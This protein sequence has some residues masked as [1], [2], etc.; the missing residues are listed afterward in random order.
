MCKQDNV[1]SNR[2]LTRRTISY[3]VRVNIT[4]LL[5]SRGQFHKNLWI[6]KLRICS[7]YQILTVNL[8]INCKNSV[9][10]GKIAINYEET[11]F[12]EDA[13]EGTDLKIFHEG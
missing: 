5:V 11:S 10:N 7:Y 8:L 12:M 1:S 6:R 4:L 13:P 2:Q 9:I 3:F